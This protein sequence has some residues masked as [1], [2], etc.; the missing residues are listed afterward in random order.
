MMGGKKLILKTKKFTFPKRSCELRWNV[1][2]LTRYFRRSAANQ[3]LASRDRVGR[4]I[5]LKH[6]F[7][8]NA[9][10]SSVN[11]NRRL[12]ATTIINISPL[13]Q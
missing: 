10:D 6:A 12:H 3:T 4:I 5:I 8:E 11:N 1:L 13:I 9:S 7:Y 2:S